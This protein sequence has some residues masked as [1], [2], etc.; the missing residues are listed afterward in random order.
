MTTEEIESKVLA[1]LTASAGPVKNAVLRAA[2][3]MK[4]ER[5]GGYRDLDRVLQRLRRADRIEWSTKG[6][7]VVGKGGGR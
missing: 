1:A 2:I 7:S 3:G 5:S 4:P 6:W